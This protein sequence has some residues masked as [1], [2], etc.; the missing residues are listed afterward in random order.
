MSCLSRGLSDGIS[1]CCGI[2]A[3]RFMAPSA[4]VQ[5]LAGAASVFGNTVALAG[6]WKRRASGQP[7]NLAPGLSVPTGGRP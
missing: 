1:S 3:E 2:D 4:S 6:D 7:A 5:T